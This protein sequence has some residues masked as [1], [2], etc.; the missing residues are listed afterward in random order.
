MCDCDC[1]C[2]CVHCLVCDVRSNRAP[3]AD[4]MAIC[5][6]SKNQLNPHASSRTTKSRETPFKRTPHHNHTCA[7]KT[8]TNGPTRVAFFAAGFSFSKGHRILRVPYDAH[9]AYIFD[10]EEI[11]MGVRARATQGRRIKT[12][13]WRVDFVSLRNGPNP[14]E[15][16]NDMEI[17]FT[18]SRSLKD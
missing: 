6:I 3:T 8:P 7:G 9:T 13:R 18:F 16:E 10:G 12:A 15:S 17:V 4:I 5:S 11:S 2:D 14:G 1:D